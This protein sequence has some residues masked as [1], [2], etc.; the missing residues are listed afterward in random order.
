VATD[1]SIADVAVIAGAYLAGSIPFG[2][3]IARAR[4]VDIQEVGSKNIGATNVA[5]QLGKRVGAVVLLLDAGKGALAVAIAAHLVAGGVLAPWTVVA[6]GLAAVTGHCFSV[7][8]RFAGGKGVATALGVFLLI[9]PLACAVSVT[10][11]ALAYAAFRIASLGSLLGALAFPLA[12][13]WRGHPPSYVWLAVAIA[14]LIV[15][16]HR[17]NIGRLLGG[18]EEPLEPRQ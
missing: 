7:W 1:V 8:L 13:W 15:V 5:R 10:L 6:A 3:I 2:V 9:D 11:F 16:R 14:L 4:G 12:L 17:D 18:R